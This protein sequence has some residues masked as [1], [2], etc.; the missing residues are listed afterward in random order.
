MQDS[1]ERL[2]SEGRAKLQQLVGTNALRMAIYAAAKFGIADILN[3]GPRSAN[4]LAELI[5]ADVHSLGRIMHA[6]VAVGVFDEGT[7]GRYLLTPIS[8]C[9]KSDVPSSL[10]DQVIHS[11]SDWNL[12]AWQGILYSIK[13]GQ[14]G[15]QKIQGKSAFQFFRDNPESAEIFNSAMTGITGHQNAA[16]IS[17]YD[18]STVSMLVDIGGGDGGLLARIFDEYPATR[19][20]IFDLPHVVESAKR[21]LENRELANRCQFVGG[22]FFDIAPQGG[23]I[24][25]LKHIMHNWDDSRA[26]NILRN[27][28]RAMTSDAK[29]LI[30]DAIIDPSNESSRVRLQ[31]ITMLVMTEGGRERTETEFVELLSASNF[32]LQRIISA[33]PDLKLIEAKPV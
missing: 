26:I 27:I 8:E 5:E 32:T 22:D 19:G 21:F 12:R 33:T 23:D 3:N 9:L 24:Y 25:I 28:H 2:R 13:T 29:L 7:D 14:S 17:A 18:F 20:I 15:F 16:I 10:R 1:H 31:D 30:I 11:C 4:E 6:L